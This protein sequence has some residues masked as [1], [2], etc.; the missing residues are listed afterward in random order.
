MKKFVYIIASAV[1]IV[2]VLC[3][4]VYRY[5]YVPVE[6]KIESS[7]YFDIEEV[8]PE[9]IRVDVI[10]TADHEVLKKYSLE[11]LNVNFRKNYL[12]V[13]IGRE[14]AKVNYKRISKVIAPFNGPYEA[15]ITFKKEFNPHRVYY[16]VTEHTPCLVDVGGP[17]LYIENRKV[18]VK[19]LILP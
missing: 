7:G 19:D 1:I 12:I 2:L 16:Y 18:N 4:W 14:I 15:I 3:L 13:S 5:L 10:L 17:E 8:Q 11:S 9:I 6:L